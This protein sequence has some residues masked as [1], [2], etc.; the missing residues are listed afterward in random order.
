MSQHRR[1]RRLHARLRRR[2]RLR[3]L[4]RLQHLRT[5]EAVSTDLER[6][7]V[8]RLVALARRL[9][10]SVAA[11]IATCIRRGMATFEEDEPP[12]SGPRRPR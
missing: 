6:A 5:T 11:H 8:D 4:R 3:P 1:L 7:E 2:H 12:A 9:E 10:T